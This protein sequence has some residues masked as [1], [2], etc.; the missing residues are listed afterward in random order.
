MHTFELL[1]DFDTSERPTGSPLKNVLILLV[2]L[3]RGALANLAGKPTGRAFRANEVEF[4]TE[5]STGAANNR[6]TST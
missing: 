3:K 6:K 4:S 5:L 2:F 1:T